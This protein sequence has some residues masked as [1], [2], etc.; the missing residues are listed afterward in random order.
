MIESSENIFRYTLANVTADF[1]VA[2]IA[3]I[4]ARA[5]F[6]SAAP[7]RVASFGIRRRICSDP[8]IIQWSSCRKFPSWDRVRKQILLCTNG[9]L[10]VFQ[11]TSSRH[12]GFKVH[13]C[14]SKRSLIT[15]AFAALLY[16]GDLLFAPI[17]ILCGT[18]MRDERDLG[19]DI[20]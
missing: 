11:S 15:T 19:F 10:R 14:D 20:L 8:T 2:S 7:R 17:N 6:R 1:L 12:D 18:S 9:L 4:G 13:R 16:Y 5:D 3:L